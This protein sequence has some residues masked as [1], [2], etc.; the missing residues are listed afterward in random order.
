MATDRSGRV[1]VARIGTFESNTLTAGNP[2]EPCKASKVP[3][4]L[5][6]V[7]LNL[8]RGRD[9]TLLQHHQVEDLEAV[10]E[11]EGR[12]AQRSEELV[13]K[14]G[15]LVLTLAG[16]LCHARLV[17]EVCGEAVEKVH[18]ACGVIVVVDV[19]VDVVVVVV[20]R[21]DGNNNHCRHDG[22]P[23]D[24]AGDKTGLEAEQPWRHAGAA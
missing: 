22:R 21:A 17:Q 2:E 10:G 15:D 1:R 9:T 4:G 3:P 24:E 8:G 20:D 12:D 11:E 18:I 14:V 6:L 23:A 13:H 5:L 16:E 7:V 19:V